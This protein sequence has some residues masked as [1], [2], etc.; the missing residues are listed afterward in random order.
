MTLVFRGGSSSNPSPTMF[1]LSSLLTITEEQVESLRDEEL[2]LVAS[3]F[4]R[5]HNNHLN[6][7]HGGSKDGCN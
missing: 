2:V 6:W 3:R 7:Q 1:P 5:F 4:T